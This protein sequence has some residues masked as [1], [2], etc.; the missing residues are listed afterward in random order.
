MKRRAGPIAE[1]ALLLAV[2]GACLFTA[3]RVLDI[4]WLGQP[5]RYMWAYLCQMWS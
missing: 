4:P 5:W 2:T 1:T 3:A